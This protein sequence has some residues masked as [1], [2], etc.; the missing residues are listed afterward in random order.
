[1]TRLAVQS[2]GRPNLSEAV[3]AGASAIDLKRGLDRGLAAAVQALKS[4][5][6]P[7]DS[8]KEKAQVGTISALMERYEA[9]RAAKRVNSVV[10]VANDIEVRLASDA[11]VPDPELARNAVEALRAELPFSHD[12]IKVL[13]DHGRVTLEGAVDWGYQHAWAERTVRQLK[14]VTGVTNLIAVS[15]RVKPSDVKRKIQDAFVRSA[16]LD[17]D[18]ISVEAHDGEV[19]L[20][21]KVRSIPRRGR[22]NRN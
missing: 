19:I 1:M 6:K 13:V 21:G 5:A 12:K 7:V 11:S 18:Q 16:Q 2:L 17:A 15:P 14:G 20:R 3:V 4:L 10:G 8:R 22:Q 9:E